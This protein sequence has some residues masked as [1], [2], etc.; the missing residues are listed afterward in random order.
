MLENE[1]WNKYMYELYRVVKIRELSECI[2]S[3]RKSLV[4][5]NNCLSN[6]LF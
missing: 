5:E 6:D 3:K 4:H 2:I 1:Q